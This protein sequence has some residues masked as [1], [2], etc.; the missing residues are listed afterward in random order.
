VNGCDIGPTSCD[1]STSSAKVLQ[2]SPNRN[3]AAV[4]LLAPADARHFAN[5][6]EGAAA[7][8]PAGY[9]EV[10]GKRPGYSDVAVALEHEAGV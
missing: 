7:G 2:H 10:S 6:V 8:A 5:A 9:S 1:G 3:I 4:R